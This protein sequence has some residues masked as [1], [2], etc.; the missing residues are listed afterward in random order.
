MFV[1]AVAG[2]FQGVYAIVQRINIPIIIQPQLFTAL[3]VVSWMQCLYYGSKRSKLFCTTLGVSYLLVFA[4]LEVGFSFALEHA[5]R[6]GDQRGLQFFGIFSAIL[7]SGALIPQYIEIW[8][9]KEVIGLS[10][11]FMVI[12]LGGG[13]FCALSLIFKEHFDVLAAITYFAVV[14][15]DGLILLLAATLNPL[16]E[17][18]RQKEA[19]EKGEGATRQT[20]KDSSVSGPWTPTTPSDGT[21]VGSHTS[22]KVDLEAGKPELEERKAD[23]TEGGK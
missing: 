6:H 3:A 10:L 5:V 23:E 20:T 1:W 13:V 12:D 19:Q 17:R 15:L 18:R 2:I 7:I 16:A 11:A 14:V 9:H 21:I 4:G 8:K 22:S